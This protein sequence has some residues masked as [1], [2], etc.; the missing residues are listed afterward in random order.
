MQVLSSS[1]CLQ[2]HDFPLL[3]IVSK[4]GEGNATGSVDFQ[5]LLQ[6]SMFVASNP[7]LP[8][9]FLTKRSKNDNGK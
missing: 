2:L 8:F 3:N 9:E 6:S 5:F 7:G 1:Q 4:Y